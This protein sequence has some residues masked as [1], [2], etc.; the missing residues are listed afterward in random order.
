MES[1]RPKRHLIQR[2]STTK[3][4]RC[5]RILSD[6]SLTDS[7]RLLLFV[8]GA[9]LGA[10]GFEILLGRLAQLY[11]LLDDPSR[12]VDER[13]DQP[14]HCRYPAER[15]EKVR[16]LRFNTFSLS[17]IRQQTTD[18]LTSEHASNDGTDTCHEVCE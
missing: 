17:T 1:N 5:P 15:K 8:C 2:W 13:V 3:R 4:D 14:G 10:S 11:L 16:I 7:K 12:V 18:G 6:S 9:L